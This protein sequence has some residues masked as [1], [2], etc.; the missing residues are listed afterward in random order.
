MD[1]KE[2]W[3]LLGEKDVQIYKLLK[4]IDSLKETLK[5]VGEHLQEL[6]N[7]GSSKASTD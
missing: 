3:L 1:E 4:T 2:F 7:G 5:E 6:E